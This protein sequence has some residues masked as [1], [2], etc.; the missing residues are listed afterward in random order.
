[1][2]VSDRLLLKT[3]APFT[4]RVVVRCR[5]WSTVAGNMNSIPLA[6]PMG[7]MKLDVTDKG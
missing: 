2:I 5:A 6:V 4:E 1:M 3:A 7:M